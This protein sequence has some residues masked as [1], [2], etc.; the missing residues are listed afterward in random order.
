[1]KKTI[2][3][4]ALL[5]VCAGNV[6]AQK[7]L[8][9][10]GKALNKAEQILQTNPENT[11][12]QKK[13]KQTNVSKKQSNKADYT[14][15]EVLQ[16]NNSVVAAP[17][18]LGLS[19]L[20][21]SKNLGAA[22]PFQYGG[23]YDRTADYASRYW[24]EEWRLPTE[25]EWEELFTK[26][27]VKYVSAVLKD[28]D[29]MPDTAGYLLITG[30]NGNKIWLPAAGMKYNPNDEGYNNYPGYEGFYWAAESE[31]NS[32]GGTGYKR[33]FF[34]QDEEKF[35]Y[36]PE[37]GSGGM[38]TSIRLVYVG[39]KEDAAAV[40]SDVFSGKWRKEATSSESSEITVVLFPK[41]EKDEMGTI[42]YGSIATVLMPS[43]QMDE[44]AITCITIKGNTA[45]IE[46]ECMRTAEKG[47]V[48]LVYNPSTQTM[49]LK[50]TDLPKADFDRCYA[51]E[52]TL[53]KI[54]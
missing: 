31:K 15:S 2:L 8:K 17:V 23:Y 47:K 50:V 25:K 1:M 37:W 43:M 39:K 53:R 11:G 10:I 28:K 41:G 33:I 46:Y 13:E 44:D 16:V 32:L 45:S 42:T 4:A 6:S 18:D 52:C 48:T 12:T 20:W 22:E 29:Y 36:K 30:S 54:E 34:Q 7:W 40:S 5:L 19:V 21:A 24:G 26:C 38:G 27:Q 51:T 14:L 9:G 49:A 3:T 35:R